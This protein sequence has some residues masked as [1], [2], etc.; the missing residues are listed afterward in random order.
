MVEVI[1]IMV[2]SFKI[3][4]YSQPDSVPPTLQQ[5]TINPCLCQRLLDTYGQVWFSLLW[6]HSLLLSPG[7]WCTQGSVCA[8]QVS[9]FPVLCKLW[10]FY[11]GVNG[12][13]PQ[14]GL[15]HTQ[16]CCTQR[17][18]PCGRPLLTHIYIYIYTNSKHVLKLMSVESV[19]TSNHLI[20]CC[21]L[22][23]LP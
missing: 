21:S 4:L 12:D 20:L 16:V 15:C 5:S 7:S 9:V 19:M 13:L 17:P 6:V 11:G 23:L 14:D 8:L 3:S 18:Y 22:L 10:Q 2:T 1:E